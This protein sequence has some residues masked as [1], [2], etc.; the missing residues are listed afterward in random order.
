[1]KGM[2]QPTLPVAA[3]HFPVISRLQH[4]LS[5]KLLSAKPGGD[6]VKINCRLLLTDKILYT[7]F[8]LA[9]HILILTEI[10]NTL[11]FFI[12]S[13]S[14]LFPQKLFGRPDQNLLLLWKT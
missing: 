5:E 2:L 11:T 13:N 12:P 7:A 4:S 9:E 6:E 3:L 8:I 10:R 1:M 14:V